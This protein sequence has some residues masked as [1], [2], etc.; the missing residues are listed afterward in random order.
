MYCDFCCTREIGR[1]DWDNHL[2]RMAFLA[3]SANH[4]AKA[5]SD[6]AVFEVGEN[7]LNMPRGSDGHCFL[8]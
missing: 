7:L 2:F 1:E 6:L 4:S 8:R 5:F 3:A